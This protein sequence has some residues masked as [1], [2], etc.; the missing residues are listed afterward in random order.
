MALG[1]CADA[2][3]DDNDVLPALYGLPAQLEAAATVLLDAYVDR[4]SA[5]YPEGAV[6][7]DRPLALEFFKRIV[8]G[9]AFKAAIAPSVSLEA[10]IELFSYNALFAYGAKAVRRFDF[11]RVMV[12][13]ASRILQ[14][15]MAT[16]IVGSAALSTKM[17]SIFPWY[18]V[19]LLALGL[20][21]MM[22]QAVVYQQFLVFPHRLLMA[23]TPMSSVIAL[24]AAIT[25]DFSQRLRWVQSVEVLASGNIPPYYDA[26]RCQILS[27]DIL[28]QEDGMFP[29]DALH[30]SDSSPSTSTKTNGSTLETNGDVKTSSSSLPTSDAGAAPHTPGASN[31]ASSAT[32]PSIYA[33]TVPLLSAALP[34]GAGTPKPPGSPSVSGIKSSPSPAPVM[35]EEELA[36]REHLLVHIDTALVKIPSYPTYVFRDFDMIQRCVEAAFAASKAVTLAVLGRLNEAEPLAVAAMSNIQLGDV[37]TFATVAVIAMV[38]AFQVIVATRRT[39]LVVKGFAM[40]NACV[41]E[42]PRTVRVIYKIAHRLKMMGISLTELV[43]QSGVEEA[44]LFS[45][46]NFHAQSVL[47]PILARLPSIMLPTGA[48]TS[49]LLPPTYVGR[50]SGVSTPN[51]LASSLGAA[52]EAR[53]SAFTVISNPAP[54]GSFSAPIF[55]IAMRP[56]IPGRN[57]YYP[58]FRAGSV[59]SPSP[60][61]TQSPQ[62]PQHGLPFSSIRS[63]MPGVVA[64]SPMGGLDILGNIAASSPHQSNGGTPQSSG[65]LA[66]ANALAHSNALAQQ[67]QRLGL[68]SNFSTPAPPTGSPQR[69]AQHIPGV[70][71]LVG[72]QLRSMPVSSPWDFMG[73]PTRPNYTTWGANFNGTA[74]PNSPSWPLTATMPQYNL[75][76]LSDDQNFVGYFS[77]NGSLS[78]PPHPLTLLGATMHP[79]DSPQR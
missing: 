56:H 1:A 11:G 4:N 18:T 45:N 73:N 26:Y 6:P 66:H 72:G 12:I 10:R 27:S 77:T 35:S 19:T 31:G 51:S 21:D 40:L 71:T 46:L 74:A 38:S 34:G 22:R 64:A 48:L 50:M 20:D 8:S 57:P 42:F 65:T 36:F 62:P 37:S 79:K 70:A 60:K 17:L 67:Q 39:D 13:R 3:E 61:P 58:N 68:G 43:A 54:T 28:L 75:E 5:F 49:P 9:V 52:S 55:P 44:K 76:Q 30:G 16:N 32:E 53:A 47:T 25:R 2:E 41:P 29:W 63:P 78:E 59:G 24:I 14:T 33:V 23:A 7:L 15:I 69:V